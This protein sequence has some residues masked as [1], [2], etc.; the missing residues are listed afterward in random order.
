MSKMVEEAQDD[1]LRKMFHNAQSGF[2]SVVHNVVEQVMLDMYSKDVIEEM[3]DAHIAN[4]F[5]SDEAPE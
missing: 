5:E 3:K 4:F 1:V 2:R